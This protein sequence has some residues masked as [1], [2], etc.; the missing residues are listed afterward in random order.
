ML[1][2]HIVAGFVVTFDMS[3]TSSRQSARRSSLSIAAMYA[4]TLA[5]PG[6]VFASAMA[7]PRA[8]PDRLL[9]E[10]MRLPT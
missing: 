2:P 4:S 3:R 8:V 9:D 7:P 6:L 5:V 1:V 10:T